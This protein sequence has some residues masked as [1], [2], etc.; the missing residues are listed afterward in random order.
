MKNKDDELLK[1]FD[2]YCNLRKFN[3]DKDPIPCV[4]VDTLPPIQIR[5]D[6]KLTPISVDYIKARMVC[7]A[8]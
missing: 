2:A 8:F 6:T 7:G 3:L 4:I 1:M 5:T